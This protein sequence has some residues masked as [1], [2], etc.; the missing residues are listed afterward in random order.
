MSYPWVTCV[1]LPSPL[2][3]RS[4]YS[5]DKTKQKPWCRAHQQDPCKPLRSAVGA[6]LAQLQEEVSVTRWL[7]SHG[8]VSAPRKHCLHFTSR[9]CAT[10]RALCLQACVCPGT[11]PPSVVPQAPSA[12]PA[13]EHG[14]WQETAIASIHPEQA[15]PKW[16]SAFEK[17]ERFGKC[18]P[19]FGHRLEPRRPSQWC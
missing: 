9:P 10:C 19:S 8:A 18:P 17:R 16:S 13:G 3:T 11:V 1:D 6:L 14:G 4:T 12:R 15:N 5:L 2:L 7:P